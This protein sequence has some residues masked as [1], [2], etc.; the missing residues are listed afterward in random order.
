M[1]GVSSQVG[2]LLAALVLYVSLALLFTGVAQLVSPPASQTGTFRAVA[3]I[4]G[5]VLLIFAFAAALG[6]AVTAVEW[7]FDPVLLLLVPATAVL[8][9]V[10]HLPSFLGFLQPIRPAH[11]FL[12]VALAAFLVY[13]ALRRADVSLAVVSG[14]AAHMSVDTGVFPPFSPLS[15]AYYGLS[16][17]RP[18]FA[19]AALG[20]A[21]LAGLLARS[22][23]KSS[24]TMAPEKSVNR[25]CTNAAARSPDSKVRTKMFVPTASSLHIAIIQV[26]GIPTMGKYLEMSR[27]M[28]LAGSHTPDA[29]TQTIPIAINSH[30]AQFPE[31][32][33]RK[34][35][36]VR[37]VKS[38]R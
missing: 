30:N 32:H 10:D 14:F 36:G 16:G 24:N 23:S 6:I 35:A 7:R 9:D 26:K 15:F 4:P 34:A 8:T 13:L 5:H 33:C 31:S 21:L 25:T 19:V 29:T 22:R 18:Y 1:R 2:V 28:G 3:T 12:F 20:F 17:F 11:S 38:I 27:N 37:W